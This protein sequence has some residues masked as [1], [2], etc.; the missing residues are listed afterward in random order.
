MASNEEFIQNFLYM[1]NETFWMAGL[2]TYFQTPGKRIVSCALMSLVN[3]NVMNYA[4]KGSVDPARATF[5]TGWEVIVGNAQTQVDLA[6]LRSLEG[7]VQRTGNPRL[8]LLGYLLVV[9]N[10]GTGYYAYSQ[11]SMHFDGSSETN[12]SNGEHIET[13]LVPVL[14]PL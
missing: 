1:S 14:G 7:A 3:S 10:Q 2:S 6:A 5:D 8:R 9:A 13:H 11:A 12:E 4:I